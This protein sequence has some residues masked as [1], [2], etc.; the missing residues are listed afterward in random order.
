MNYSM[1]AKNQKFI[2]LL[3][4]LSIIFTAVPQKTQAYLGILDSNINDPAVYAT[5]TSTATIAGSTATNTTLHI[6]DFAREVLKQVLMGV[7]RKVLQEMT[8][9]TIN[10]INS[11]FHGSPLF[12][13]NPQSFFNDIA[14]SEV[15]T[16]VDLYGYDSVKFPFG[17]DFALN[18][19]N[20]Y[21]SQLEDNSAYTLSKTIQDPI[22][23][24][25]YQN[26]FNTGGWNGFLVN[27][28]YPQNNYLGFQMKANEELARR[29][30]GTSQGPAQKIQTALQQGMG[31]LSP[32]ACPSNPKYNNGYNE[33]NRPSFNETEWN[34]TVP[35][36]DATPEEIAAWNARHNAAKQTWAE[37]NTCPGGLVNTTPGSVVAN[38][39][40]TSLTS[41]QKQGELAAAMGNSLSAIFD[42]LL[43]KF[44]GDGLNSLASTKNS[45][46]QPDTWTYDGQTLGSP[47]EGGVNTTWD[48]GPD[49]PITLPEFK[50]TVD[51]AI[52]N[53]TLELKLM[54]N[55]STTEPGIMQL[56][57]QIW[58]KARELDLCVPGPDLGWQNRL[59]QEM[60]RNEGKLGESLDSVTELQFAVNFFKDWVNN[61]IL[62]EIP[63]SVNYLDAVEEVRGLS[64]QANEL[65]DARREKNQALLR[66]QSIK[67]GLA[68]ITTQPTA[69]T[70]AEKNLI[71]LRQQYDALAVSISNTITLADRQGELAVA[72]N[73]KASL[74]SMI[75]SCKTERSAKGW[76]NPGGW[77]SSF[78]GASTTGSSTTINGIPVNSE[79]AIFCSLPIIGGYNHK[80]F[81][82]TTGI[83]HPNIPLVN[84]VNVAPDVNIRLSCNTIFN[85]NILEYKGTLP[86]STDII[87]ISET[88]PEETFP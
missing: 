61:K 84:A 64:Q 66:L 2:S 4:L 47:G 60:Q 75:T 46:S 20:S 35:G 12:L 13:E 17:K 31:F 69:G 57:G 58:P 71:S 67:T 65:T 73:K 34:K 1:S 15:K 19:I 42:A 41:G 51:D 48:S 87:E 52:T 14:K 29:I 23:L 40:M 30:A 7:A 24:H 38:Q 9:S 68:A 77:Q 18:V 5:A 50:K 33:F 80:T 36:P 49:A 56:L 88:P 26:D 85:A 45:T 86:G 11:G 39:I 21:K 43:N 54:S 55:D 8:K 70:E 62:S 76:G 53:T 25:N 82:N 44:I 83:T 22:I 78:S 28:Q 72:K 79:Q 59:D 6:K 27:T 63:D 37:E 3:I 32:Q 16:L 81:L 10:W 74:E